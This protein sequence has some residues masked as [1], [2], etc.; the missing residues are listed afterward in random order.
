[1]DIGGLIV[2]F[3]FSIGA[4]L[5]GGWWFLRRLSQA[6]FLLDTPTSK[7][8]SAAQGYVEF[9][10]TLQSTDAAILGPLTGVPC[11]WWRYK[12]EEG[13]QRD[14]R[15]SWN[16]VE[17]G[18]SEGWLRLADASGECLINPLGA[19][20]RPMTR[21]TWTG[22][23]RHPLR[24]PAGNFFSGLL[25]G[26]HYRYT[27]ERLHAGEPLYAI[28]DFH[29]SGGAS[30]AWDIERAQGAVIREWKTDYAGLLQ[31]FDS[32]SNG[33]LDEREWNRVRLAARLEAEDRQRDASVAPSL[34]HLRKPTETAPFLL[35]S[36]GEDELARSFYWQAAGGAVICIAGAVATAWLLRWLQLG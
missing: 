18:A 30:Q 35:S 36:H 13:Q 3:G 21:K 7:I 19:E 14:N 4:F 2:S 10:G 29:T 8:R 17:S 15:R 25:G 33:Q 1:M 34:D 22:D 26:K 32:D 11:V 28:G 16:V 12:I 5:G 9:Y 24:A 31:R 20:V 27:E 23:Q 6:R